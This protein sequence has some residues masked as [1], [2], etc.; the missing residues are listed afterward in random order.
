MGR[1]A[2]R[3]AFLMIGNNLQYEPKL[4]NFQVQKLKE[5]LNINEVC[6]VAQASSF[7]NTN[8]KRLRKSATRAHTK[9]MRRLLIDGQS[10][11][12]EAA[13]RDEFNGLYG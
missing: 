5:Q 7:G 12:V 6:G 13:G 8:L 10:S 2:G 11:F 3:P 1:E 9:T 4:E